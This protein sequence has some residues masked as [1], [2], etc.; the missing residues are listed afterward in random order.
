MKKR[1]KFSDSFIKLITKWVSEFFNCSCKDNPYCECGRL[2][3]ERIILNLRTENQLSIDGISDYL[4]DEYSIQ[5]FKGDIV[6]YLESLIYSF[7]SLINISKG[8]PKLDPNFKKE[9]LDI[10]K[11]IERIKN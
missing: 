11:I 10:P 4:I 6:V 7:E 1:K 9:L 3:L 2:N 8:L 5:V